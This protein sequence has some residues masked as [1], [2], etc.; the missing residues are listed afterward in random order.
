MEKDD[1]TLNMLS[2]VVLPMN[3]LY[4]GLVGEKIHPNREKRTRMTVDLVDCKVKRF[5][6][7][8]VGNY[9][10]NRLVFKPNDIQFC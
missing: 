1:L 9:S 4:S 7:G 5:F 6:N 3:M 10:N 2:R 8:N